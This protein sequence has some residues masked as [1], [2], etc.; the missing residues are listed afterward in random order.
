MRSQIYWVT[1]RHHTCGGA[2]CNNECLMKLLGITAMCLFFFADAAM[3]QQTAPTV[4]TPGR[5]IVRGSVRAR[6]EAWNW[7]EAETGDN[8]YAFS[9]N[10]LRISA[11]KAAPRWD[12]QVELAVPILL[13]LPDN[14][15]APGVQGELGLG[16]NYFAANQHRNATMVFPKQLFFRWKELGGVAG[17]SLRAGRF[18]FSDGGEREPVDRVLAAVKLDRVNQ[19]LIGPF[20]FTHVG[21][22]FD[23]LQYS[24]DRKSRNLTLVAAVP[25][26]GVFQTDGWGWNQVGFGYA[27]YTGEWGTGKHAVEARLFAIEYADWRPVLK[28][29]NSPAAVRQANTEMIRIESF[30]GH[31]LHTVATNAGT[32]DLL[33]W[34]L[35]Q[36]GRWGTQKH[37]AWSVNIE[38]GF[39]PKVPAALSP[40]FRAGFKHGSGDGD[41][42]DD[43]HQTFFQLLPTP[44]PY[45]R[46]PFFNMMNMQNRFASLIL[47]PHSKLTVSTEYH[48]LRLA[49]SNDLWYTGGGAFQPW[50]FG[51]TGRAAGGARPLANLYDAQADY[52]V[53][54]AV[55]ISGYVGYAQGRAV[56]NAI[57]PRGTNGQFGYVEMTYSF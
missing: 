8:T 44:R 30:G 36:T 42:F 5:I 6:L 40:W 20:D 55:S 2:P 32:L 27:G 29:D 17:Q 18:E 4:Q 56:V 39:Q 38:A 53:S 25:T 43:T 52:R 1:S 22:S 33:G 47:R 45:A 54:S 51:Y 50:T 14:A 10:I 46:F 9:G 24:L 12:W 21:R 34:G 48:Y 23:G 28:V 11:S 16:A 31:S 41:P 35:I 13:G 26:R 15:V 3:A 57:Y 37:R 49:N 7:F 19:R